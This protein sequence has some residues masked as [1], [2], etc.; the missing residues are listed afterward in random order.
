ML[1]LF[2][3]FFWGGMIFVEGFRSKVIYH[4][5]VKILTLTSCRGVIKC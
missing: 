3:V 2:F 5:F 4:N 1:F